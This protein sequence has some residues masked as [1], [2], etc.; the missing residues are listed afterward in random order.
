MREKVGKRE[1]DEVMQREDEREKDEREK[2]IGKREVKGHR[3]R[4]SQPCIF[5]IYLTTI[6]LL[7]LSRGALVNMHHSESLVKSSAPQR[8]PGAI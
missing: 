6:Y 7:Y 8:E 2:V 5:L 1:R 3:E 4:P